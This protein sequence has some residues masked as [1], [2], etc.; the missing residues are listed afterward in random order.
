MSS[1]NISVTPGLNMTPYSPSAGLSP[2]GALTPVAAS[3]VSFSI[4]NITIPSTKMPQG[5]P[6]L[7][8]IN[9]AQKP[10]TLQPAIPTA[11]PL[12]SMF[13]SLPR[14][15][16]SSYGT[17][18]TYMSTSLA[19]NEIGELIWRRPNPPQP[20]HPNSVYRRIGCIGDGSCF[21][22]AVAKGLSDLYK[23]SYKEFKTIDER[24]LQ[25]FEQSVGS[26]IKFFDALFDRPR[27]PDPTAV[28]S[29]KQ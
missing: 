25:L 10:P 19:D 1:P 3:P 18:G 24:T 20:V 14:I 28:Y 16:L 5:L 13:S 7:P 8:S 17:L 12:P 21:F 4:P 9:F 15:A 23:L 6:P 11:S 22:H 2:P 29:I 26:K 27:V